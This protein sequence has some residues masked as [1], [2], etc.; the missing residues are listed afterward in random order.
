M[1]Y[2]PTLVGHGITSID[3]WE[4]YETVKGD[5]PQLE[6]AQTLKAIDKPNKDGVIDGKT[7]TDDVVEYLNKMGY[8]QEEGQQIANAYYT[9]TGGGAFVYDGSTWKY[10]R[11]K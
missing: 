1:D 6:Y 2:I 5:I 9:G 10:K 11:K 8:G 3:A 4:K 7:N